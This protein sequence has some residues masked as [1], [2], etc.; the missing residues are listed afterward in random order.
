MGY[1]GIQSA[2]VV[3]VSFLA[4]FLV[5]IMFSFLIIG[6]EFST[7]QMCFSYEHFQHASK[8]F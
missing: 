7:T 4:L 1:C 8:A 2:K 3:G 5:L 6:K